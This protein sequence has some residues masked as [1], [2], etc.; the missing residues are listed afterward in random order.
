MKT[1]IRLLA[2]FFLLTNAENI[3][4]QSNYQA[5]CPNYQI[6]IYR[7]GTLAPGSQ[8]GLQDISACGSVQ[9]IYI[10]KNN[11]Y[12][13]HG[14]Y[15]WL[16][17]DLQIPNGSTIHSV[18]VS[19]RFDGQQSSSAEFNYFDCGL[20]ISDPNLDL[21]ALWNSTDKTNQNANILG[22]GTISQQGTQWVVV[23]TYSQGSDFVNAFVNSIDNNNRFTL[24]LA[25]KHEGPSA[26]NIVW[27]FWP[28]TQQ[29]PSISVSFTPPNQ[30][31]TI[32]QRNSNNQQVGV[33]KKYEYDI[34]NWGDPFNPGAQFPFPVNSEQ[35]ILGD[36]TVISN[37][38]YHRWIRNTVNESNV[39][40]HHSFTI[41]S[42]DN[43]FTSRFEPTQP[44][45]TIKNSLEGTATDGGQV[46]FRDPWFIDYPDPAFGNQLRN[47]G[48]NDA[49]Y[50]Q[51]TSPF[52]PDYQSQYKGVFLNQDPS[53]TPTYYKVGMLEEQLI[54]VNGQQRKFFPYKWTGSGVNFQ[55]E[56]HRQTGVVFT[57]STA[58]ATA[59]LKG[60][61]MSNDQN[62]VKNPS[63]RKMVRTDNGR[64]H[65]VYES[66]GTVFYTY[67]LTSDFYGAWSA[68][69]P[70]HTHGKN[71]AIA[72]Y[73]NT[74]KIV[75]EY[76]DPQQGGNAK[77]YLATYESGLLSDWDEVTSYPNSY[78]G[79][80]KPVISYTQYEI[81][82]AYR[83]GAN[84]GIKY[85]TKWNESNPPSWS[86]FDE[87][88]DI[89]GT[90]SYS[91]NPSVI[92]FEA[93]L[94]DW[95]SI[96]Y[97]E[98]GTIYFRQAP[99]SSHTW[100][101]NYFD[102]D[103]KPL[104]TGSGFNINMYPV[105]SLAANT[106]PNGY[107]M[108]SWL[109]IF[110][111]SGDGPMPKE[112][113]EDPLYRRAAVARTGWGL[114]W[115][116]TSSF[117]DNVDYTTNG[118]LNTTFGSIITWS[119][120][121]GEYSKWV[122]RRTPFGY[123][124]IQA[125]STNGIHTLVSNGSEFANTKAMVFNK[126][127]NAPYFLNRCTNDFTYIPDG[128]GK[129]TASGTIDISYGRSGIIE[130][131]GIEFVFNIGDVLLNGETIKFIE[132]ADTLPVTSLEELNSWV[133]TDTLNLNSQSE[134]IF[135]DYYY[136]VFADKADS[137]LS[138]EFNVNFKCELVKLSTGEVVGV[139]EE[140]NYNKTNLEEF[141]HQGYLVDCS[142]IEAGKY[143][144]KL[145][146]TVNEEAGLSL[147]DIQ[148]DNVVLNKS[149]LNVR[150]FKGE[151]LPVEYALEQNYPNP[152]NP[153]TTI[154][155]QL[156][157][158]GMVTLKVYDI[159]GA[160]V[161]TLVNEEKAAG[162]YEVNFNANKLASGVYIY[163]IQVNEFISVKKM[164]LLK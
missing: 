121:N 69:E 51:R 35:T 9:G 101:W 6:D 52:Y 105:I 56:S 64:Y 96:A 145:T 7:N 61:L 151:T 160:E 48:M 17:D 128:F 79:N 94:S 13:Y 20:N 125:L 45:I 114:N 111:A 21:L 122:R 40:N 116:T 19:F 164:V 59:V 93:Y 103:P 37:Q 90:G 92:G 2:I 123:D 95:I 148:M 80:A 8:N 1:L 88:A 141:G 46:E 63:Q 53:Q 73:G 152:F 158:D 130:K 127:T 97:E 31:V 84:G 32:D 65:V 85:V 99:R 157:K 150:N 129:L 106:P 67:S 11:T 47:R 27:T 124:A 41:Q 137:L 49:I 3:F 76:Y 38:K 68:D 24:G 119:E 55:N 154:R 18:T 131:N 4:P 86:N 126:S 71:P 98:L 140:V 83:S 50:Y 115:G 12:L 74:V 28:R 133:R 146:T 162:K 43:N 89:P 153:T 36:Q 33:L 91:Q 112:T 102:V 120:S 87:P 110:D 117:S 62:G 143:Y 14:V 42:F 163:R 109:G 136:V 100:R 22:Y 34:S 72:Y 57:S 159:L 25:W 108:V 161:A 138:S 156:P 77:I 147:A 66:M 155:Y 142:G 82:V 135:S 16:I 23:S 75:F 118:S 132:R 70:L 5:N 139:F 149:K 60:Q 44:G 107:L 134:L 81:F 144:L 54:T 10:G 39:I 29:N 113:G 26:G 104:S 58:T 78:Y 30:L 15:Q